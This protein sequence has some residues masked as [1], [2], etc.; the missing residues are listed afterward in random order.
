MVAT[1][2]RSTSSGAAPASASAFPAAVAAMSA[3]D[4]SG[5]AKQRVRMPL[6]RR[7]HSG[8]ESRVRQTSSLVTIRRGR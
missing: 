2:I 4:S 7:I 6:R 8:E 3:S 5:P 1:S